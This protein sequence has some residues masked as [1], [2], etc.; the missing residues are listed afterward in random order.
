MEIGGANAC[1]Q[2]LGVIISPCVEG[3]ACPLSHDS[4]RIEYTTIHVR[5]D[6]KM[7]Y[8]SHCLFLRHSRVAQAGL[9][10]AV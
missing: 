10:L 5:I 7:K 2:P 1:V 6:T 4:D 3:F 8:V 9:R